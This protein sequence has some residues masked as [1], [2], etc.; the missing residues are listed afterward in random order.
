MAGGVELATAYVS[1]VV[2]GSAIPKEIRKQ[3]GTVDKDAKSAGKKSGESYAGGM[4]DRIGGLGKSIFAPLA[5]AGAAIGVKNFLGGAIEEARESQ[6]VGALTTQVIKSTGGA[7][8]ISA[9]QVG[10]LATAIS[11]KTGIDDEAVQSGANLLL[12]FKN[13]KNEAG[14]GN[15]IFNQTTSIMTD[16]ASAMGKEP[17]AAAIQLGK[18]LNDPVKGITALSKVGVTFTEGQ[19]NQIKSLVSSGKTMDAQK[20]ILNELKSEFGGAAEA[21]ATAGEKAETAW[22][23]FKEAVGTAILPVLDKLLTSLGSVVGWMTKNLPGAI[24]STKT[25]LAPLGDFLRDN[26]PSA[27]DFLKGAFQTG[28]AF[29]QANVVPVLQQFGGFLQTTVIPA[30]QRLGGFVQTTVLPALSELAGIFIAN[31]LPVIR[32]V[33]NFIT[34]S[35]V[36]TLQQIG[37]I[38]L[39]TIVPAVA[40]FVQGFIANALPAIRSLAG[41]VSGTLVPNFLSLYRTVLAN[42]IPIVKELA[43]QFAVNILPALQSLWQTITTKVIPVLVQIAKVVVPVVA[44][45]GKLV[46]SILGRVIPILLRLIGPILG[47]VIRTIGAVIGWV[48]KFVGA[49]ISIG[50][51]IV[52]FLAPKITWLYNNIFKPYFRLIGAI[53]STYWNN[54]IKPV[55]SAIVSFLANTLGPKITWLYNTIVKP[56][57][58]LIGSAIN[59]A[60]SKVI[61]PAFDAVKSG[62]GKLGDAFGAAKTLIGKVWSGVVDK[63]T[64]PIKTV[65]N[66]VGDHFVNPINALLSKVGVGLRIP[67]PR[68]ASG[69]A[70]ASGGGH[71]ARSAYA[72]GGVLPGYSP[73]RD[74]LHFMGPSGGLSLSGGEAVMRPE[75]T[76]AIG[77]AGVNA[78]NAAARIGGVSGVRK[79]LSGQRAFSVGGVIGDIGGGVWS[80]IKKVGGIAIDAAK[81]IANPASILK[82]F[83]NGMSGSLWGKVTKGALTEAIGGLASKVKDS[84]TGG[85]GGA[86]GNGKPG[87]PGAGWKWQWAQIHKAFPKAVLTSAYRPGAKTAG[88]GNTSYHALGRAVDIGGSP[89]LMN[90]VFWWLVNNYGR[91][92]EIIHTPANGGKSI[93]NGQWA[94]PNAV[95]RANHYNHTHWGFNQGGVVP[96]DVPVFDRGGTLAPGYNLVNN[97]TGGP[98]PLVRADR[99]D[100]S[101]PIHIEINGVP[102]DNA[103]ATAK[104]LLFEMDRRGYGKYAGV[105]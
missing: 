86:I 74:N 46:A 16:M 97:K 96:S 7:A 73:G 17:K 49:L 51:T 94:Y 6:K 80:G 13:I 38:I 69:G 71:I 91:S 90:D 36:P 19:K 27:I 77:H 18:A 66:W 31:V 83:L 63:I 105:S 95:T 33:G 61:K 72:S 20:I 24:D 40:K 9:D 58:R 57:F 52:S 8:K 32:Q 10:D 55:F 15:D 44:W 78:M 81:F 11:N 54:V 47:A 76:R 28:F 26:L 89:K 70:I 1:L 25:A 85:G 62:V 92:H 12:T 68:L 82:K 102:M 53:I 5:A 21:Q 45:F 59:G 104:S 65:V 37:S 100:D 34:T 103:Q 48:A 79:M 4:K 22:N 84:F 99:F 88:Y 64:G 50:T 39:N 101:R 56:Y 3:F 42:V 41:F 23:N 14:T 87:Q 60:W 30:L 43:N 35:L 67:W 75:W 98:E 93:Y 2:E 29:I